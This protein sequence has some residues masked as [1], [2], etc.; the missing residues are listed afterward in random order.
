MVARLVP[1]SH[2]CVRFELRNLLLLGLIFITLS[3]SLATQAG[4]QKLDF[5][6]RVYQTKH[7]WII[8]GSKEQEYIV[9]HL[10]RCL[11]NSLRYHEAFFNYAPSE[12]ITIYLNDSD[13]YGYAGTTTLPNN[14]LTLGIEPFE[15]VYDTCP[16]NERMNWV[17][18]HELVHVVASDLASKEDRLFRKVFFGKVTPTDE[19]PI[20][21]LFSYLTSPRRYAPRWYHE[22]IA[23]FMETWMA[24]GIGR[25]LTGYDEMTF[26]AMVR[27]KSYFYDVVGLESEGTAK[28]FQIG[29]NS[30]FY[31]TRFFSYLAYQYGPE[32][33]IDWVKRDNGSNRYF[34]SQF[35]KIYGVPLDSEWSRWI[36]FEKKWQKA[37]LDSI[38]RYPTTPFRVLACRPLGSVSREFFDPGSR[39]LF[40]AI[41]Y[42]GEFAHVAAIN[43][44][45]GKIRKICEIPTPAMYYVTSL[46]YD[47]SAS[48]LFF[49][50]DNSRS[51]R[52]INSV[53]TK[54]GK[55]KLLLKN[56]RTG[57]LVFDR[58]DKSLWGVQHDN[59]LSI[60]VRFEFPYKDGFKI[61]TL[62]YGKDIFD[63]DVSPDGK[64][65]S[66]SLSEISGRVRLVRMEIQKLLS[67]DSSYE[68]LWEFQDNSPANFVFSEDGRYLFGTSY[69]TGASN[70][71]RYDF[72][73]QAMEPISNC[74][75]GFFRP[76]PVS[77][78]SLIVFAY[79]GAGFA[80]L[81]IPNRPIQ[82]V[83]AVSYLGQAVVERH[84]VVK[85]WI[86]GSPL[87]IDLD[88][89]DV[90]ER[91][92][93]ASRSLRFSSVY[94]IAEGYKDYVAYGARLNLMDPALL[95]SLDLTLSYTP[96]ADLPKNQ[97]FHAHAK[98]RYLFW[99]FS[100]AYNRADF[101]D[102]FGPTKTSRK[103]HSLSA[104]YDKYLIYE[105]PTS[106]EYVIQ[107]AA[108]GGLEK[109]PDFQ[110]VTVSYDK[111]FT[112]TGELRYSRLLKTIGA[113][114][115][116]KGSTSKLG[117]FV[118]YVKS[119][120][121]PRLYA[122]LDRGFLTPLDHASIWLRT[123]I[124]HSFGKREDP[125]ANFYFGGFGNNWVDHAEVDRYR[126]YY[127]FPGTKLD[128][129][130]WKN[131]GK[132]LVELTLPPIRFRRLGLPALYCNWARLALFSGG[133]VTNFDDDQ[134]RR[135]LM[136]LGV[137]T[138]FKVVI[139]S[140]LES[141]FSLGYAVAAEKKSRAR[142]EFMISLK[143]LR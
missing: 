75:T 85:D 21:V 4:G 127:S 61:L 1:D 5:R 128:A 88:T 62:D 80:P 131:F 72:E 37:N 141:T 44:D 93:S 133:V 118:N 63:L 114:E 19:A 115:P 42:P 77:E 28:D 79:S 65:L 99:T 8:Y 20:S 86:L 15:Y 18:N 105:K 107:A 48:T 70:V 52:D 92:Y 41:N 96:N 111:F 67:G 97:R 27:D 101:Y 50:T 2:N 12:K 36:A 103:G 26:R 130:E 81:M 137:Q 91:F 134:H 56:I 55:T 39:T 106:L 7:A 46:A 17:M 68:V 120:S 124:G 110:N 33:A 143:I 129:V 76:L 90:S 119:T 22:G 98:Y 29:Q 13:D 136:D 108:Y 142:D 83:S 122:T 95:N 31:G 87:T 89:L 138:N 126:E 57:D 11:E 73:T 112:L 82:D 113:I 132:A 102:L 104:Q 9:E 64:Y 32:K 51:W 74:E 30:Y 59:G 121:Y 16:T 40:A 14:W 139:F 53:D 135:K 35:R 100:G 43:I 10:A 66:A 54:S 6:W 38:R 3:V 34:S 69:Y 116:E 78:D 24:G 109:L 23:V 71:W 94:P 49:T 123:S 140:S 25:S 84:P 45:S 60:L 58:A 47:D 117:T 125:F